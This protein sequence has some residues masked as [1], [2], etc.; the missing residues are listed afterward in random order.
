MIAESTIRQA[1]AL[2]TPQEAE[3]AKA[4]TAYETAKAAYV[5]AYQRRDSRGLYAALEPLKA[6]R[7]ELLRLGA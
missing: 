1:L 2:P 5:S 3:I 6:A 7:R 4:K